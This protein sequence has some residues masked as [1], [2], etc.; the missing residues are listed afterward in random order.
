[1]GKLQLHPP[2]YSE[3]TPVKPYGKKN[4]TNL[5]S[6]VIKIID[7]LHSLIKKIDTLY[8]FLY[9]YMTK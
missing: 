4:D 2:R 3:I 5:N 8:S 6:Q 9:S 7:T 1:M